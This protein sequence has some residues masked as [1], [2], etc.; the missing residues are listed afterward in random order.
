MDS[1][2]F[3]KKLNNLKTHLL[4]MV[5]ALQKNPDKLHIF[6]DNGEVNGD[7]EKTLNYQQQ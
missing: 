2:F 3:L 5:P 7:F 6:A 1:G 4:A